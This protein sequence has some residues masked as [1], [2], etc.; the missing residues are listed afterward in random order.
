MCLMLKMQ[1]LTLCLWIKSL[2]F[3][4]HSL[5]RQLDWERLWSKKSPFLHRTRSE[6]QQQSS[7]KESFQIELRFEIKCKL[8]KDSYADD[9]L[10]DRLIGWHF[11]S[12]HHANFW[13]NPSDKQK[14]ASLWHFITHLNSNVTECS[15]AIRELL[16]ELIKAHSFSRA[17]DFGGF[18]LE[19]GPFCVGQIAANVF[20]SFPNDF[21]V[22]WRCHWHLERCKKIVFYE[23]C[24]E[25]LFV[26]WSE[27]S[28]R[29]F[30]VVSRFHSIRWKNVM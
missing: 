25:K 2:E 18:K 1:W 9:F 5:L 22:H 28:K 17:D 29:S 14:F 10:D 23:T 8:C 30:K 4:F 15:L 6:V 19:D 26:T 21:F 11:C 16:L 24:V 12:L 27:T 13:P 3:L 20:I 7:A